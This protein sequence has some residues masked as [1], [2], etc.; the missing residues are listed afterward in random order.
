[1][2]HMRSAHKHAQ[3]DLH[4]G[5][6][7][8]YPHSY[9]RAA[10]RPQ[11]DRSSASTASPKHPSTRRISSMWRPASPTRAATSSHRTG[12]GPTETAGNGYTGSRAVESAAQTCL[13]P[14]P[15]FR[16]RRRLRLQVAVDRGERTEDTCQRPV[17][18]VFS[19]C[20]PNRRR[21]NV[22]EGG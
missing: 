18:G 4:G 13:G 10:L 11:S 19:S 14:W 2:E 5:S 1:M 8:P 6:A 22:A 9:P 16:R 3:H 12:Y 17:R 7:T 20:E 15:S 21:Q